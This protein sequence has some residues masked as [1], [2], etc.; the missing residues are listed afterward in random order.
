MARKTVTNITDALRCANKV[1]QG[2]S[3][4][5]QEL[6]SSLTLLHT[7]YKSLKRANREQK[8]RVSFLE[9]MLQSIGLR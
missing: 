3:C 8:D 1:A 9:R 7:A 5:M 6:K 4:T 2:K